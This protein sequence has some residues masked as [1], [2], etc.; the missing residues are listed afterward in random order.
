MRHVCLTTLF[1]FI[2]ALQALASPDILLPSGVS[3]APGQQLLFPLTLSNPAAPGGVFVTLLSSDT[4][5]VTVSPSAAFIPEGSTAARPVNITGVAVGSASISAVASNLTGDT[6]IVQVGTGALSGAILLPIG[7]S[8]SQNG[9]TAFP[10]TLTMPAP[11][12]GVSVSLSSG[13]PSKITV[14]PTSVFI[15][16]GAIAPAAQPQITAVGSGST[17]VGASA[18]GFTPASQ[19]VQIRPAQGPPALSFSPTSLTIAGSGTST[20]QLNLSQPLAAGLTVSLSSSNT[21]AVTV[22]AGVSFAANATGANV[23]V[24]GIA[25]GSATI[26]A[27]APNVTGAS[28]NVAVGSARDIVLPSGLSVAPGQQVSFQLTLARP[29]PPGGAFISLNSSDTSIVSIAPANVFIAEGL[30]TTARQPQVTGAAFGSASISASASGFTGDTEVVLVG[31]AHGLLPANLTIAGTGATQNLSMSLSSTAPAGGLSFNLSS[32]NPGVA[33]VPASVTVPANSSGVSVPV[34]SV[35]PGTTII[36]SS[37]LPGYG[38][39]TTTVIVTTSSSAIGLPANL[40]V[41]LGQSVAFAV[42]LGTPAPAGGVTVSLSGGDPSTVAVSPASVFIAAGSTAPAT[43][44]QITGLNFGSATI[45]A[46]AGGYSS[47]SSPIQV[48]G[49]LNFSQSNLNL[50]VSSVQNLQLNLSAPTPTGLTVALNSSNPAATVPG[51]ATFPAG[52]SSVG[53]P[54][55]G[56]AP[57]S[58]SIVASAPNLTN[59]MAGIS[60]AGVSGNG[61]IGLPANVTI[62]PNQPA[63]FPITLSTPAPRGG[64][65]VS[66]SSSAPSVVVTP[67]VFIAAGF[68]K[69]DTQPQILGVS[70]GA[71]TISASASGYTSASQSVQVGATLAFSPASL[72]LPG[73]GTNNIQLNLSAPAPAGGLQIALTSSNPASVGVP[74]TVTFAANATGV[75]V[76]VTGVAPGSATITAVAGAPNVPSAFA[77]VTVSSSSSAT[78]IVL[79]TGLSMMPGDQ[80]RFQVSLANPAPYGGVFITLS[81]SDT[82]KLTVSP[83]TIFMPQGATTSRVQSQLTAVNF[84]FATLSASAPGLIGD[85]EIVR[86]GTTFGFTP[87]SLTVSEIGATQNL[88]LSL[89]VPAPAGGLTVTLSSTN[90][91]VATVPPSVTFG[92]NVGSLNVPVTAV[93]AGATVIHATSLLSQQDTTAMVS[94]VTSGVI[95]L[96]AGLNV[97]I[98]VSVP[99]PITLTPPAPFG[100][101]TVTLS[102]GDSSKSFV[103]PATVFIPQGATVPDMQPQLSGVTVGTASIGA[104][105]PGYLTASQNVLVQAATASVTWYG[106]CWQKATLYGYLGNYQ[107]IDFALTTTTPVAVEG[108]LFFTPNCQGAYDNMND[109]NSLT[110]STHT[111]QGFSHYP[112]V[113]PSSAVYWVGGRTAD[114]MCPAGAPCSG[115]VSYSKATPTCDS[116]P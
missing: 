40:S 90:P 84:G 50:T 86:I 58:A 104:S 82:T 116:L 97:G 29:S 11:G 46:S 69:P 79:P 70:L 30:T 17:T 81:S 55:T 12:N 26:T 99:F 101:V 41:P 106:A 39:T 28:A 49:A 88:L 72:N 107:A 37:A 67:S 6:E 2:F 59:A 114:G 105:A 31:T 78:D 13:D 14:S 92:A 108:S 98:G 109:Y 45:G 61:A 91:G 51:S 94:V 23:P 66:L 16:A 74:A 47:A 111:V 87:A 63:P 53:V 64:V 1:A 77:S 22:P 73:P 18:P 115:C 8:L 38:D 85:G 24:T 7:M 100:G 52:S 5:K 56:V 68:V 95:G 83:D 25:P 110:G 71:A 15:V 4:S 10:V 43:Q 27:S 57:G 34:T 93:G 33:T 3:V 112:D 48:T 21:G 89:P 19:T 113:I 9:S 80:L 20:L 76:P 54:V 103:S 96:P 35:G 102:S 60:V 44:P 36:H 42:T 75:N 65:T 32:S 62:G